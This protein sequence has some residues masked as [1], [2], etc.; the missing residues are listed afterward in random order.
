MKRCIATASVAFALIAGPAAAAV[1]GP[2]KPSQVVVLRA[3]GQGVACQGG[4]G[5]EL[6]LQVH[7]D[8]SID[9]FVPPPGY[10]FV[11]TGDVYK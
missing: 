2:V 10:G 8:G 5:E 9:P 4:G 1:I 7:P 6:D 3:S 11:I